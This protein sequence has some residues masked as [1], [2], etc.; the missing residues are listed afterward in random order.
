ME[1][2]KIARAAGNQN[3]QSICQFHLYRYEAGAED[4]AGGCL[5]PAQVAL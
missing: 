4:S 5:P 3:L 2:N 1:K